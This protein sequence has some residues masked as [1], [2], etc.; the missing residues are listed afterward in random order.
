MKNEPFGYG[1]RIFPTSW[2]KCPHSEP[3]KIA[4]VVLHVPKGCFLYVGPRI[5]IQIEFFGISKPQLLQVGLLFDGKLEKK[6]FY[7][8]QPMV[9]IDT[10]KRVH[11]EE[12]LESYISNGTTC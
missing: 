4:T 7:F 8:K 10:V 2:H 3:S 11:V 1:M 6:A 9:L 12:Q 5:A